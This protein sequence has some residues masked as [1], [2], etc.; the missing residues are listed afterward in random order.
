LKA[1]N[2]HYF[3]LGFKPDDLPLENYLQCLIGET[4]IELTTFLLF[5]GDLRP[6]KLI[7]FD[8]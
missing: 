7:V 8:S 5:R 6:A 3:F 1:P 2:A 4:C